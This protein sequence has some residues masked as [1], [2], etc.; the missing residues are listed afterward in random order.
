MSA[1]ITDSM[2]LAREL[3][4]KAELQEPFYR[5]NGQIFMK[6]DRIDVERNSIIFFWKGKK[7]VTQPLDE[8]RCL[9]D[10]LTIGGIEGKTGVTFETA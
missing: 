6:F 5:E 1:S 4:E 10:V 7:I 8:N 9:N 3:M 2:K